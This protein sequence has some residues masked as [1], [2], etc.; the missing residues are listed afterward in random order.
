MNSSRLCVYHSALSRSRQTSIH[1]VGK[2]HS[3]RQTTIARK[4]SSADVDLSPP[5]SRSVSLAGRD[6]YSG[7]SRIAP[8]LSSAFTP[9]HSRSE[10]QVRGCTSPN[11]LAGTLTDNTLAAVVDAPKSEL[12]HLGSP[13]EQ[14]LELPSRLYTVSRPLLKTSTTTSFTVMTNFNLRLEMASTVSGELSVFCPRL[15]LVFA[16]RHL[17][18]PPDQNLEP[19]P[20]PCTAAPP[21][22]G[23]RSFP[24][25]GTNQNSN[26]RLV[27][28]SDCVLVRI[29]L[30]LAHNADLADRSVKQRTLPS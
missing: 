28:A 29:C 7:A 6:N 5:N 18:S 24:S 9:L 23:H 30:G 15:F 3:T 12:R 10:L 13:P 11:Y 14:F 26:R 25:T 4:S 2:L 16:L 19:P 20:R 22:T 8:C 1:L 21:V 27:K 17:M